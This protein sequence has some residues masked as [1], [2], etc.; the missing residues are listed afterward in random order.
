MKLKKFFI[1]LYAILIC[2]IV[3]KGCTKD[4][5]MLN[6]ESTKILNKYLQETQLDKPII[7]RFH[8][9]TE[10]D[11]VTRRA[12]EIFLDEIKKNSKGK[13]IVDAYIGGELFETELGQVIATKIGAIQ[14][15]QGGDLPFSYAAPEWTSYTSLPFSITNREQFFKF[16]LG[17]AGEE[18][19]QKLEENYNMHFLDSAIG[20]R[21]GRMITANKPIQSP[22][23]LIGI[24][25][26]VP[27]VI[28]TT[29]PWEIMGANV[30]V[31][32][33]DELY[34]ALKSGL[35]DAQENPYE[36]ISEKKLYEVQDY[37][38]ETNHQIG[39]A[40]F[41][42]NKDFWDQL[43]PELKKVFNDANK[44]ALEYY[45]KEVPKQEEKIKQMIL[46]EG[47]TE[48]IPSEDIDIAG[49]KKIIKEKVLTNNELTKDWAP[50]GWEY[51]Q[52]L[53]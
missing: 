48:I 22:E 50:G 38:M 34:I 39:P 3:L 29:T 18:I 20:A 30:V 24:R 49:L 31:V 9:F 5:S 25:L 47:S 42:V 27:P 12:V 10:P 32:P 44:V 14:G 51:I 28:G 17:E 37:I 16:Y 15:I 41:I 13:I 40:V 2:I 33:Y 45:N 23:D 26:R 21:G 53:K 7:F 8:A 43:T 52:S 36:N 1:V 19:N 4:Q 11:T 35:V 46:E 6:V